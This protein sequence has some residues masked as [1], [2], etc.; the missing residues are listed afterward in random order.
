MKPETCHLASEN[1]DI[2]PIFQIVLSQSL[3]AH[4]TLGACSLPQ[5][6][7]LQAFTIP[8]VMPARAL[9]CA[10]GR[11]NQA[12]QVPGGGARPEEHAY[13]SSRLGG[14]AQG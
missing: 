5:R 14:L 10:P 1:I 3:H 11:S 2:F 4:T 6:S 7:G 8:G 9:A 12:G 13:R